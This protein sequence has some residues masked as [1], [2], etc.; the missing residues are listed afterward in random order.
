MQM[1]MR[2]SS[3]RWP[4]ING[5]ETRPELL[6]AIAKLHHDDPGNFFFR[7]GTGQDAVDSSSVIVEVGAGGLGLPDRD[8]Y[9]KT[10]PKSV[11]LRQQYTDYIAQLLTL[12]G[13]PAA[14]AQTDADSILHIETALAKASLTR[15]QERDPH[16]LYHMMPIADVQKLAPAIN[17]AAYFKEQGAPGRRE[18]QRLAA[19]VPQGAADR[20]DDRGRRR[21]CAPIC[22]S[23]C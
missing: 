13:E 10:D 15:V 9:L 12:S 3:P 22:A 19:R 5:L 1:E 20:A 16:N 8:Y 14:Q 23:T 17:W 11:K 6:A 21:A 7:A 18:A 2:P 4:R